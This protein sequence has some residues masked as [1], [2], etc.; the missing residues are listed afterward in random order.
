MPAQSHR[1]PPKTISRQG[2]QAKEFRG[3][4]TVEVDRDII[5]AVAA[6]PQRNWA[7]TSSSTS[8]SVDHF[9]DEPR[10][11][12]VYEFCALGGPNNQAHLRVK[13]KVSEDDPTVDSSCPSYQGADWHE[14][15]VFD[16]MGI[17]FNGHPDLRRILMWDGYPFHPLRKD[18]PLEGL[19][20]DLPGEEGFSRRAPL[21]GG[22]FV[23]APADKPPAIGEAP[24]TIHEPRANPA[25]AIW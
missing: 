19:P 16:M 25:D 22:P 24:T 23:A 21:E 14:R 8:R 20:S 13:V 10:Y 1:L 5:R 3:E 4:Q 15:E 18:F 9:G 17:N 2:R 12:V 6:H 11:E 7:S